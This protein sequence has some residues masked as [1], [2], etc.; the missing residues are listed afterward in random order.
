MTSFIFLNTLPRYGV[1]FNM[2]AK[3]LSVVDLIQNYGAYGTPT[4]AIFSVSDPDGIILY[5]NGGWDL[6]TPVFTSPD[7]NSATSA[8]SIGGIALPLTPEGTVKKGNYIFNAAYKCGDVVVFVKD[9]NGMT[10]YHDFQYQAPVVD[11]GLTVDCVLT[12]K[13]TSEDLT[14]YDIVLGGVTYSPAVSVGTVR[15][16]TIIN[17]AGA[18]CNAPGTTTDARRLIGGG[19]TAQ[20]DL[21][22]RDWQTTISTPLTYNV[23]SWGTYNWITITDTA[24]GSNNIDVECTSC[25][26]V[27]NTCWENLVNRWKEAERGM[28][29]N[30]TDLRHAVTRG[31][32]YW[33]EYYNRQQCGEDT[34][35]VCRR[36]SAL[37][38]D[39]DCECQEP[40]NSVS[41]R[42]TGGTGAT[43]ITPSTFV[44]SYGA[45]TY[46]G[47]TQ[48]NP[49]D[50]HVWTDGSTYMYWE[51]NSG[52]VWTRISGNLYGVGTPGADAVP[53]NVLYSI[54]STSAV[55][56][57]AGTLEKT[58][59][60]YTLPDLTMDTLYDKLHVYA[61]FQLAQNDT[62][63]T[64]NLYWGGDIIATKFTDSLVNA[65]NNMITV[66]AWISRTAVATQDI[67]VRVESYNETYS[68]FTKKEKSFAGDIVI[69]ATGQVGTGAQ[70]SDI[71]CISFS[72][73]LMKKLP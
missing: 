5:Q 55:G 52:G 16:H 72:V 60:S 68:A 7:F 71:I 4:K 2:T 50:F 25:S 67:N 21:W 40:D 11:I 57:D 39:N 49:N 69:N 8:W 33:T 48:G 58:L 27:L 29:I 42:I 28:S 17:P 22:T 56:T 38:A 20:T 18:G 24:Y 45:T 9:L 19:G 66:D 44:P 1:T 36:L 64:V 47:T 62:P 26:C 37:I 12:K 43:V 23:A 59:A 34:T 54:T 41:R 31:L 61:M 63:K 32:A 13:L 51:W 70:A 53:A 14:L 10:P 3:E 73:E 65:T 35:D 30:A 15:Q 46:V 6:T